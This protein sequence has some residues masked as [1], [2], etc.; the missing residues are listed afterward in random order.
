MSHSKHYTG[1]LRGYRSVIE[2]HPTDSRRGRRDQIVEDQ[3]ASAASVW[4]QVGDLIRG[5]SGRGYTSEGARSP[6]R[7][8]RQLTA[9]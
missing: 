5:A 6:A 1:L 2:L 4:A 7:K 8:E 9:G 3:A